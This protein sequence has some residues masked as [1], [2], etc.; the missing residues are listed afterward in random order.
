MNTGCK[1]ENFIEISPLDERIGNAARLIGKE[2]MLL[3]AGSLAEGYNTMTASW[4][5]YGFLWKKPVCACFIRPQRYTRVFAAACDYLT[6]TFFGG[7][8][9]DALA[10]CGSHSGRD[11]DKAKECGLRPIS[12]MDG[13]AV[14]FDGARLVLILRKMYVS[15][16]EREDFLDSS[17]LSE[18]ESG[19]FH[20]VYICEVVQA[21][22][23]K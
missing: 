6:L 8:N 9:E 20:H 17:A 12:V 3:T 16:F 23:G 7:K 21:L 4:G 1:M 5:M 2:K 19:D 11:A 18:Y 13:R 22:A 14:T 10:Y 15:R